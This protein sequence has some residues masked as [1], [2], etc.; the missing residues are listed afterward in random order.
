MTDNVHIP[1]SMLAAINR[2][3]GPREAV[4][5]ETLPCPVPKANEI[6]VRI[7]A[8]SVSTGDWRLRSLN[9]PRGFGIIMRLMF[10]LR[11][12]RYGPLGTDLAGEVVAVGARVTRFK[13]G[14]RIVANRGMRLGG[15]AQYCAISE[16][17]AVAL[18]P[19][20]LSFEVATA[21]VFG[22]TTALTFLRDKAKI[23]N[24]E[25][26][27][28]I[29]A[30]GCVGSAA[31]QLGKYFG[32]HVTGVASSGKIDT[33]RK[34]GADA[35]IDYKIADWHAQSGAYDVIFDTVGATTFAHCQHKLS[36]NGRLLLAVADLPQ[37]LTSI[38]ISLTHRKKVHPG[39]AGENSADLSFL[40]H[41]TT[42]GHFQPLI[43]HV[44]PLAEISE[45]YRIVES[46]SKVGSVVLTLP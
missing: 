17:S 43:G 42:S 31:V 23:K 18:I 35:V 25:K 27:L 33:V 26:L 8:A 40:V 46:G 1:V 37:M 44:L 5:V 3:Y 29:G 11:R 20:E 28:V 7:W 12:P 9:V 45:A 21:L 30:A 38:W 39:A 15:H 6:L 22:G 14:D 2:S 32:A 24:G 4:K 16:I 19:E 36:A 34:L 13:I 10:G 41:L